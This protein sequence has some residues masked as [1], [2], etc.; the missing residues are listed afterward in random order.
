MTTD[1]CLPMLRPVRR[2]DVRKLAAMEIAP[3]Q[4]GFVAPN[5]MTLAQAPYE[6]GAH[7]FA[8]WQGEDMVGLLAMVDNRE[9][10]HGEVGDDPNSAFMWRLMIDRKHQGKGHGRAVLLEMADWVRSRGLARIFTSVVPGNAV[11]TRFYESAGFVPT[12]R[13]LDGEAEM[14]LDLTP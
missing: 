4:V 6:T 7:V 11:A 9:Y 12:G 2:E 1:A 5:V 8:V 10:Q 3:D 14:R 13:F